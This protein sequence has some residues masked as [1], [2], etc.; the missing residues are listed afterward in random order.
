MPH[1]HR[2][3]RTCPDTLPLPLDPVTVRIP[4]AL[5]MTGLGRSKFYELIASGEIEA[6]KIGRCTLIPIN[7]LKQL[8]ENAR[9]GSR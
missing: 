1:S 7:S 3:I 8:I 9:A 4:E 5:Q 2:P 6:I